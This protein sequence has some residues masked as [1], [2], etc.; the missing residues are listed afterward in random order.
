MRDFQRRPNR[1]SVGFSTVIR[2]GMLE[3]SISTNT[4]LIIRLTE[5]IRVGYSLPFCYHP[6]PRR[7]SFHQLRRRFRLLQHLPVLS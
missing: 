4:A 6:L 3:A 1:S 5:L 2:L 7:Q